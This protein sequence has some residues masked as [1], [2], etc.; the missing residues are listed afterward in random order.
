MTQ[1]TSIHSGVDIDRAV[2]YYKSIDSYGRSVINCPIEGYID[3]EQKGDWKLVSSA[4][5]ADKNKLNGITS[6]YYI[7]I[8]LSGT[9]KIGGAPIV[10]FI[11]STGQKWEIDHIFDKNILTPQANTSYSIYCLSN[12]NIYSGSIVMVGTLSNTKDGG[13][14]ITITI[15]NN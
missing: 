2:A 4:T 8:T 3:E 13:E 15:S 12:T 1:Y 10:Y 14:N 7:K 6:K 11:D 5:G 9:Y